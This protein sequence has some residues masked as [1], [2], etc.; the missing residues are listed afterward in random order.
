[1]WI[2]LEIDNFDHII[3]D[4]AEISER[5]DPLTL[6]TTAVYIVDESACGI[7]SICLDEDPTTTKIRVT[8]AITDLLRDLIRGNTQRTSP[9]S[10][11]R[12]YDICER[13]VFDIIRQLEVEINWVTTRISL[14]HIY[15]NPRSLERI[16]LSIAARPLGDA[17]PEIDDLQLDKR[18]V[19][20]FITS[21]IRNQD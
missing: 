15:S 8:D 21:I 1:M 5:V 16:N 17:V 6:L 14:K 19:R 13:V 12:I 10:V 2:E 3:Q 18:V 4:L 20:N 11:T 9:E 7:R